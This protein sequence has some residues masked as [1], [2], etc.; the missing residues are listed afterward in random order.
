[1]PNRSYLRPGRTAAGYLAAVLF[2]LA[3]AAGQFV[4][5]PLLGGRFPLALFPAAAIAA[6]WYGN[7]GPGLC[8]TIVS[9][10]LADLLFLQPV[11]SLRIDRLDDIAGLLMFVFAG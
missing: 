4:L 10:L 1:M 6:A 5:Q 11:G 8:A 3:A 9:A 7:F 2:C